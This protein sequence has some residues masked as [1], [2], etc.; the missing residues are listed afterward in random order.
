MPRSNVLSCPGLELK[1]IHHVLAPL[2]S[3]TS[4][5]QPPSG[6]VSRKQRYLHVPC[7]L[8]DLF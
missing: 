6:S 2:R 8:L 1:A 7:V 5:E 4:A 3:T